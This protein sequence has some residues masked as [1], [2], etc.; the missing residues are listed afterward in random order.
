M[1]LLEMVKK[2]F[3]KRADSL[4]KQLK[5]N[6]STPL[7]DNTDGFLSTGGEDIVLGFFDGQ[8]ASSNYNTLYSKPS[9]LDTSIEEQKNWIINYRNI[10]EIPEVAN[11][12]S[13][14][15]DEATFA[16]GKEDVLILEF[17][18]DVS[19]KLKEKINNEFDKI[20]QKIN[21]RKNMYSLFEKFYIDGQL[22]I[23]VSYSK[24]SKNTDGIQNIRI[25]SPLGLYYSFTDQK[26]MYRKQ[27]VGMFGMGTLGAYDEQESFE[28]KFDT[29]FS[30]EEVVHIDSGIYQDNIILSDLHAAVKTAN[31]IQTLEEMLIPMRFNRSVSRRVFNVDVGQLNPKKAEEYIL[32]LQDRFKFRKYY[33]VKNGTISNQQRVI[34]LNEDYW[35]ASNGG[36]KGTTVDTLD[37]KGSLGETGDIEYFKTKLYSALK[38]PTSRMIPSDDRPE[39]DFTATNIT[40]E[41]LKFFNFITRKRNQFAELFIGLL[42]RQLIQTNIM[43]EEEFNLLKDNMHIT[44]QSSNKFFEKMR[45]EQ[46]TQAITLYNDFEMLAEKGWVSK[47]FL[48][49]KVLK[50][51]EQDIEEM[52]AQIKKEKEDDI[53]RHIRIGDEPLEDEGND[54]GNEEEPND[55][56][57]VEEPEDTGNEEEPENTG[58]DEVTDNDV[59]NFIK[60]Y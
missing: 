16:E 4:D 21:I 5:N 14:V 44:W 26:W 32:K 9:T 23:H 22:N 55:F 53:Y 15:V 47:K 18:A 31:M 7:P 17:D 28:R 42:K 3:L 48:Y 51:N 11:A 24:K 41:E 2:P 37:E 33:D 25:L 56:G 43:N 8:T 58:N 1:T 19:D 46:L 12:I 59:D 54:F 13:E 20:L 6:S 52:Q 57:D 36:T 10:A 49:Q 34:S 30:P 40:R 35:F 38:V 45:D 27:D 29:Q 50:F 39:F 60:N